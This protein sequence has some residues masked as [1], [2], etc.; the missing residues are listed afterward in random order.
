[1]NYSIALIIEFL[2]FY[3]PFVSTIYLFWIQPCKSNRRES[4]F[5]NSTERTGG[6]EMTAMTNPQRDSF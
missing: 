5:Q 6:I 4:Y 2:T 1:M 3:L